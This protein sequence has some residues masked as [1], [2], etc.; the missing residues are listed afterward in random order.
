MP[1]FFINFLFKKRAGNNNKKRRRR[2][3]K[4]HEKREPV[5][6]KFSTRLGA[7]P[8]PGAKGM[9]RRWHDFVGR[10]TRLVGDIT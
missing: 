2:R 3:K 9:L 8:T 7:G 10:S 4:I 6:Y 1:F 5:H